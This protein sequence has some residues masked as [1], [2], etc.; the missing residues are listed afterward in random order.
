MGS[1]KS[2]SELSGAFE[3]AG[4]F[5]RLLVNVTVVWK[6]GCVE[7]C[8]LGRVDLVDDGRCVWCSGVELVERV[9]LRGFVW[10]VSSVLSTFLGI[11]L[12]V[13]LTFALTLDL[14]L[15]VGGA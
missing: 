14:W 4:I 11:A 10:V 1:S 9:C 15:L 12:L 2:V 8:R 5:F 13:L 7:H 3:A 6:V